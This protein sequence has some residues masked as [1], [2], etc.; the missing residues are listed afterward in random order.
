ME[1]IQ[2]QRRL[3]EQ[4]HAA[5]LEKLRL[6]RRTLVLP[7]EIE[8]DKLK[9][10]EDKK[11]AIHGSKMYEKSLLND[12]EIEKTKLKLGQVQNDIICEGCCIKA[13]SI[14]LP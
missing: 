12:I 11:K 10:E 7:I 14:L 9:L 8:A 1:R 4:I 5:Q 13:F 3:E 6:Q 2:K